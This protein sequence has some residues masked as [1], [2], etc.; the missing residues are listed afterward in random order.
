MHRGRAKTRGAGPGCPLPRSANAGGADT[1]TREG[2][3]GPPGAGAGGTGDLRRQRRDSEAGPRAPRSARDGAPGVERERE[4][5]RYITRRP[6]AQGRRGA[7]GR[8]PRGSTA[9]SRPRRLGP[10]VRRRRGRRRL[11]T[12]PPPAG[13]GVAHLPR[14]PRP[15]CPGPAAS[16]GLAGAAVVQCPPRG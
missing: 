11:G 13:P 16:S 4:V 10:L 6:E 12:P 9:S 15:P 3:N 1:R 2:M 8:R 5:T 14:R 7:A